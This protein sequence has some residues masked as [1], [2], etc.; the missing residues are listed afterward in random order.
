MR[1][2]KTEKELTGE[3]SYVIECSPVPVAEHRDL[4]SPEIYINDKIGNI[5]Y[6]WAYVTC[7]VNFP[8]K[9]FYMTNS[10]KMTEERTFTSPLILI[11]SNKTTLTINENSR[12][13]YGFT[14]IFQ[15]R[16]WH[17]Y[18]CAHAFRNLNYD[19]ND[20]NFNSVL[21][22]FDGTGTQSGETQS[23]YDQA[24]LS[25]KTDPMVQAADFPGYTVNFGIDSIVLCDETNYQYYNEEKNAC[26]V[27]YN[28]ARSS[29]DKS[30]IIPSSRTGRYSMDFWFF[31]ENSAELSPGV[32]LFWNNHLSITILRDTSNKNT[33][34]AI[35]FPQ[36]YRDNIDK[37][38]GQE[39]IDIYDKA[40]NKDK[41]SFYQGSSKWNFVR[42]AVDQTRKLFYINDNLELVLEGE[43]L[44][45][46]TRNYRPFRYFKINKE[47]KFEMQNARFNPTRIFLGKLNAIGIISTSD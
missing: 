9:M 33:I 35:C 8:E 29:S 20:P 3:I 6:R 14:F 39:I 30:K 43:I 26:E 24:R 15:L 18:N 21:H 38:G 23:F 10:N 46:T 37:K 13:G 11:P 5:H 42:C 27:H 2:Y 28:I 7:G 1:V 31:V 12:T 16:L 19:R 32:N 45:G 40:I 47:D 44:Y 22:D 25:T 17:C 36:S 41:Y 4:S 34:N